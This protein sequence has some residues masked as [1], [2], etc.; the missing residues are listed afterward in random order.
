MKKKEFDFSNAPHLIEEIKYEKLATEWRPIKKFLIEVS[1][2]LET[3]EMKGVYY[4][5]KTANEEEM[6]SK[7]LDRQ[8][9]E[10]AEYILNDMR[11]EEIGRPRLSDE[12]YRHM[13]RKGKFTRTYSNL[14]LVLRQDTIL[15]LDK[16][17]PIT[18]NVAFIEVEAKTPIGEEILKELEKSKI[19]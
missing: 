9:Q 14:P 3:G 17:G 6:L 10:T 8:F 1:A 5:P 4:T 16:F 11:E 18:W 15:T 2:N 19:I 7:G 12:E 13:I